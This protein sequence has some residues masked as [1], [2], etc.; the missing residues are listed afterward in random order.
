MNYHLD[1][2]MIAFYPNK[3]SNRWA[4][5]RLEFVGNLMILSAAF[6]GVISRD[7]MEAGLAG[8]SISLSLSV[9]EA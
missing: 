7:T 6:C 8:V 5:F 3:A 2:N 1:E 9:S 4:G